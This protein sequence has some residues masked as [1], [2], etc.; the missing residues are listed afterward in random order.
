MANTTSIR[1]PQS[2][3]DKRTTPRIALALPVLIETWEGQHRARVHNISRGGAL[4]EAPVPVRTGSQVQFHCGTIET[5]GTVV[6]Q[7]S[8][9]FGISFRLPIDDARIAQQV[10]RSQ[11]VANI[12]RQGNGGVG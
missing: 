2:D 8:S 9:C 5:Q 7:D 6:W 11:A 12:K 10:A 3:E 1:T 4:V